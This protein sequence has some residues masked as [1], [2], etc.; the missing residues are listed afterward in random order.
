MVLDV[1][2]VVLATDLL[3]ESA[4]AFLK[5][6]PFGVF[7]LIY[8]LFAGKAVL[9]RRLAEH[10]EIDIDRLPLNEPVVAD[11][12]AAHERGRMVVLATAADESLAR[13]LAQ[14]LGFIDLVI[15]S[16]GAINLKGGAKADA[17]EARFPEGFSYFGDSSSD[18][19]VWK[20]ARSI[21]IIGANRATAAAAH[22]HAEDQGKPVECSMPR[23]GLG[24]KGWARALRLHQWAKNLLVFAPL[25][26]AGPAA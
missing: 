2:G 3:H 22:A 18:L 5:N 7:L 8:W 13:R 6:N 24:L 9:K 23:S 19:H 17:L 25:V 15:A 11:A 12:R 10:T 16:D 14:R 26:L 1:D 21:G 4:L 20:R